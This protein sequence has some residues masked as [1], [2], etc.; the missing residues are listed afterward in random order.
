MPIVYNAEASAFKFCP[1]CRTTKSGSEFS[2]SKYVK[3]GLQSR[4]K[5]CE[6]ESRKYIETSCLNCGAVKKRR[7]YQI[8]K[9]NGRCFSCAQKLATAEP[10][11]KARA[12]KFARAQVLRQGG[13][14]NAKHF[15]A[16]RVTGSANSRWKGGITPQNQKERG[17]SE[18]VAWRK[19]VFLRDGYTCQ[20][21]GQVGRGLHAHHKKAWSEFLELRYEINNGVT[22]CADCHKNKAHSGAWRNPPVEWEKLQKQEYSNGKRQSQ[23]S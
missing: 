17:S 4:C 7:A 13:V 5:E 19:S 16:E 15:T 23:D 11:R 8:R 9:W 3:N 20:L 12:T 6:R 21:C 14:P 22:L 18:V 2:K 10:D 1:T